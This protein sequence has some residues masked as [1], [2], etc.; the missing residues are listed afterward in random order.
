MIDSLVPQVARP[1]AGFLLMRDAVWIGNAAVR[2]GMGVFRG[3]AG[4][5]R[6]HRHWAHQLSIGLDQPVVMVVAARQISAPA[7]FV[8]ANTAHRV[9]P[10][11]L[12]SL[13]IDPTTDEA[14]AVLSMLPRGNQIVGVPPELASFARRAFAYGALSSDSF[15][16][17]RESLHL[18]NQPVGGQRLEKVLRL[19]HDLPQNDEAIS[20]K[21]LA[22]ASGLSESRF[23]HW[24]REQTGMP[25]RSYKKW[26]R[27]VRGIEQVLAGARLTEAAHIAGFSDQAHFTRTFVEMFGINPSNALTNI[28]GAPSSPEHFRSSSS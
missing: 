10:G 25:V 13:Y 27:L 14:Q 2:P 15:Y 26:L 1:E 17:F 18:R 8:P 12:L 22:S 7:L 20:R 3:S 5:N 24:F 4:D 28:D 19:L 11:N 9:L 23:S 6:A 21:L 16:A